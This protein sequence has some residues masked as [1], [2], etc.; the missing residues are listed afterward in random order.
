MNRRLHGALVGTLGLAIGMGSLFAGTATAS[1]ASAAGTAASGTVKLTAR[2]S[3]ITD[4]SPFTQVS[5]NKACPAGYQDNLGVYL[6][7]ADGAESSI[8]YHLTDGA[9]FS[10]APVTAQEPAE[11]T[12]TTYVNSIADAFGNV[13]APLVDG[14]Y[15]IHVVCGS[16]DPANFPERPT[17]TGFIDVTGDTW[18]VSSRPAPVA[19]KIK[20]TA[21]PANHVQV[22]QTFTL[23]AT[24]TPAVT[25]TVQFSADAGANPIG[26]PVAV[27]NGVASVT[28]PTNAIPEIRQYAAVFTPSD[29]LTYAQAY[30]V[31]SYAFLAA[32]SITVKDATGTTLGVNPQLTPGQQVTV[33]AAGFQPSGG[34]TV[35]ASIT[36]VYGS[37]SA[38][39]PSTTSDAVGSVTNYTVTVPNCITAGSHKL[40][41]SGED[42]KVKITFAFTT[43]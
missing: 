20:L 38:G 9:P 31:F 3:S 6:V 10:S 35:D 33:S 18:Q 39:L 2:S 8:A 21:S 13:N 36:R 11:S 37:L 23:T 5:V 32:P 4:G 40:V 16:A 34:E 42:S 15:P 28:V 27:V 1:A 41:L 7:T 19:T 29:Q 22:G 26:G 12:A 43:K 24:V 25:G 30:E 17:F 14:T